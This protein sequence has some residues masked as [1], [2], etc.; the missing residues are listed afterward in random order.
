MTNRPKIN[1]DSIDRGAILT[2][3]QIALADHSHDLTATVVPYLKVYQRLA[4]ELRLTPEQARESVTPFLAEFERRLPSFLT[5]VFL[6]SLLPLLGDRARKFALAAQ[7]SPENADEFA[8][9]VAVEILDT[10]FGR[11]PHGNVGAWVGTICARARIDRFRSRARDEKVMVR[12]RDERR[13][14]GC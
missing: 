3:L 5:V 1:T 12:A 10:C 8:Q 4:A 6:T 14:A 2:A 9:D 13:A 11:W 7:E